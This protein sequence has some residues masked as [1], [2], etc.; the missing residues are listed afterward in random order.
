MA[1]PSFNVLMTA[2][3]VGGVWTYAVDLAR[4]LSRQG[5]RTTLAVLGPSPSLDQRNGVVT[6]QGLAVV[7]TGLPLDWMAE[8]PEEVLAAGRSI[9]ELAGAIGTDLIHLN[10]PALAAGMASGR[11]I[12]A[13]CHS[14]VATWWQAVRTGPF[15]V[16]F[17]WRSD[18]VQRGYAAADALLAPSAAFA[19]AT[20]AA[21]GLGH[22]PAVVHHGRQAFTNFSADGEEDGGRS[23]FVFTAGRLWDDGKNVAAL[24]RAAGR[25]DIPVVAAGPTRA[26]NGAAIDLRHI[27]ALGLVSTAELA[28]HLTRQPIF[29]SCA[30]YEPFGL[31][32]LEAAQAGCPL[33]LADTPTFRELW[34]GAAIF[35]PPGNDADLVRAVQSLAG[36]AGTRR[37]RGQAARERSKSYGVDA[38]V[39]GTLAL[40]R[41]VLAAKAV[42]G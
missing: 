32:V 7:E 26:P 18:L 39:S 29:V 9:G 20:A 3:A 11:G 4:G 17:V 1:A 2:D 12:V 23:P 30:T 28:A 37:E 10:S 33:V 27:R 13:G 14:C 19:R 41:T 35:V 36:D 8:S 6:I 25:L 42:A 34:D 40:Y 31:A 5:V 38:M 24:D 22:P 16:D 21:Y 15:P